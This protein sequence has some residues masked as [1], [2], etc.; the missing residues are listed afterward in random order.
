MRSLVPV[1]VFL[2]AGCTARPATPIS[3]QDPMEGGTALFPSAEVF[4][5]TPTASPEEASAEAEATARDIGP[6]ELPF[7]PGRSAYLVLPASGASPRRLV[8]NLHGLCNPPGYACGYW[9]HAASEVGFLVCPEG[10]SRCGPGAYNA[11]TWTESFEA[12]SE[13]LE[14]AVEVTSSAYPGEI[15]RDGAVLT[16]FSR[17]GYAAAAIA[18]THPGR[19]AHLVLVEADVTLTVPMLRRAGVRSVAMLAGEWGS[20]VTGERATCGTLAKQGYPA[21]LFVM[22]KV[23][24][25]YSADI[26]ERMREALAFVLAHE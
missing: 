10:N 7:L 24:H 13:D 1:A 3:E 18:S 25:A 26:D 11:P 8:A 12:M 6:Y 17:G 15:R 4:D 5:A 2:F 14:R 23:G 21:R 19:W 9:T 22:P 20:Q 16:G